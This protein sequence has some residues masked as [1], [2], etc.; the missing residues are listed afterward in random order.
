M[1]L[2]CA[3]MRRCEMKT[4]CD[5]TMLIV[6]CVYYILDYWILQGHNNIFLGMGALKRAVF[7]G[8]GRSNPNAR[9]Y[10]EG[11]EGY[12]DNRGTSCCRFSPSARSRRDGVCAGSK[13]CTCLGMEYAPYRCH[14]WVRP[15]GF[16]SRYRRVLGPIPEIFQSKSTPRRQA[17]RNQAS[18]MTFCWGMIVWKN[19]I[20]YSNKWLYFYVKALF[21]QSDAAALLRYF[22]QFTFSTPLKRAFT[23]WKGK[24]RH[25]VARIVPHC[26]GVLA[27]TPHRTALSRTALWT[28]SSP[29]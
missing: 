4:W 23:L 2:R 17:C 27:H 8:P 21:R 6:L 12:H 16:P 14:K 1:R 26:P 29:I 24:K 13:P 19:K 20:F 5:A 10:R 18:R 11:N 3:M 25:N 28:E 9:R 7:C 15:C 22:N